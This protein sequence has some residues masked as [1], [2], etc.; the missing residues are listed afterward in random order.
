MGVVV[1]LEVVLEVQLLH[2]AGLGAQEAGGQGEAE[3]VPGGERGLEHHWLSQGRLGGVERGQDVLHRLDGG[4]G[5]RG[6]GLPVPGAAGLTR[7]L[8]AA[9]AARDVGLA[10]TAR[11]TR[12]LVPVI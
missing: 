6:R 1:V 10:V 7:I 8:G 12:G 4:G 5:G 3:A 9:R 2:V 11:G